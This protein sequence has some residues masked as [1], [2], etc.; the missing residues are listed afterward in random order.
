LEEFI[1]DFVFELYQLIAF[2]E[3]AFKGDFLHVNQDIEPKV[4]K[5]SEFFEIF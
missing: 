1:Q 4:Y 5:V 2:V 3:V